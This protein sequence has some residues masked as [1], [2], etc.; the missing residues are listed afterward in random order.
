V[1][2]IAYKVR[3]EEKQRNCLVSCIIHKAVTSDNYALWIFLFYGGGE[4]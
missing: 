1:I 4:K 2:Y 3:L